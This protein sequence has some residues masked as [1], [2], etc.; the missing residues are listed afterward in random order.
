MITSLVG[1]SLFYL[2]VAAFFD[3]PKAC[4]E[5]KAGR[6]VEIWL[7]GVCPGG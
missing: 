7:L 2:F 3:L 5:E 6:F 1:S 4:K